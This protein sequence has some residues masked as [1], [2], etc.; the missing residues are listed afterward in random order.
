MTSLVSKAFRSSLCLLALSGCGG[1]SGAPPPP[2]AQSQAFLPFQGANTKVT[3]DVDSAAAALD[4]AKSSVTGGIS[5]SGAGSTVTVSTD[6]SG[7]VTQYVVNVSTGGVTFSQTYSGNLQELPG[8]LTLSQLAAGFRPIASASTA[9]NGFIFGAS[10]GLS[11]SAFGAWL[12]NN[13]SGMLAF[14]VLAG[15]VPTAAMPTTG[16]ATF[17]GTTFGFGTRG[18]TAFALMG[19]ATIEADFGSHQVTTTFSNLKTQ[20]LITNAP[21]TLP[22]QTG[23]GSMTG[24]KYMT[25]ISGGGLSGAANGTFYGPKAQE[26]AGVWQSAGGST[27]AMGSFGARR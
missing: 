5:P 18:T 13:G 4:T 25:S 20:D 3:Y 21:G 15:G 27:T 8:S 26:T 16:L 14:G 11:Y 10:D 12:A 9:T 2:P 23:S 24:N 7:H 6:A 22:D 17:N 1:G 19:G